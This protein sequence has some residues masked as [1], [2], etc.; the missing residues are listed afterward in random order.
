MFLPHFDVFCDLLPKQMLGN[1]ECFVLYIY[2]NKKQTGHYKWSFFYS[3]AG[4]VHFGEDE[5]SH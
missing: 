3:K 5:K 4:L 2:S 1:M